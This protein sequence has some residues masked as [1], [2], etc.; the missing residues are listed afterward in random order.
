M[1]DAWGTM[2]ASAP[3]AGIP[4]FGLAGFWAWRAGFFFLSGVF[5]GDFFIGFFFAI[6]ILHSSPG[7]GN[8][9]HL[10]PP[11]CRRILP[12]NSDGGTHANPFPRRNTHGHRQPSRGAGRWQNA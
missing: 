7:Y 11:K 2:A 4:S 8:G 12:G 5:F 6:D 9:L 10:S 1:C 3:L